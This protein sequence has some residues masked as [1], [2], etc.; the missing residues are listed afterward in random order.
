VL[1]ELES[2]G[3]RRWKLIYRGPDEKLISYLGDSLSEGECRESELFEKQR[4]YFE[5]IRR[6]LLFG[7]HQ[8][9]RFS[10]NNE[11]HFVERIRQAAFAEIGKFQLID[12]AEFGEELRYYVPCSEQDDHFEALQNHVD[13][14]KGL[15]HNDYARRRLQQLRIDAQLRAMA[16]QVVQIR[17]RSNDVKPISEAEECCGLLKLDRSKYDYRCGIGLDVLNQII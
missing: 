2:N 4:D 10:L 3:R 14:L 12:E 8:S 6:D 7:Y 16:G 13:E 5:R 17:I 15:S 9:K 1:F 11:I